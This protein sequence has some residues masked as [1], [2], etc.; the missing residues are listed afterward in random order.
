VSSVVLGQ[1]DILR[2]LPKRSSTLFDKDA[3]THF[4]PHTVS[5]TCRDLNDCQFGMSVALSRAYDGWKNVQDFGGR[6]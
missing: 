5:T 1:G 6:K 2:Q 4:F 3:A